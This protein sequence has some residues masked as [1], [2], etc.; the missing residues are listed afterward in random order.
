MPGKDPFNGLIN[1]PQIVDGLLK[2]KL[3][4]PAKDRQ[5][6]LDLEL[7]EEGESLNDFTSLLP[8]LNHFL[9]H[10][11]TGGLEQIR[12]QI[13]AE[14]TISAYEQDEEQAADELLITTQTIA[15]EQDLQLNALHVFADGYVLSYSAED[16]FPGNVITA[17]LTTAFEIDDIAVNE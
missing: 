17:Q 5:I 14:I 12:K 1:N 9:T 11:A 4:L 2:G 16:I 15:L 10:S 13:A 8:L 6:D 7:D 3:F